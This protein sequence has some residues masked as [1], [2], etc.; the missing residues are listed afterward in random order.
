MKAKLLML[1]IIFCFLG[2]QAYSQQMDNGSRFR[3]QEQ[4]QRIQQGQRSGELTYREER[5]L[6][7]EQHHIK[8]EKCKA[9][10][11]GKI[12]KA[13]RKHIRRDQR[14][15]DKNIDRLKHNDRMQRI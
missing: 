8:G 13:E 4:R 6:K 12:S 9:R 14:N 10:R 7:K 5:K 1:S 11:D 15:A 2:I 3:S